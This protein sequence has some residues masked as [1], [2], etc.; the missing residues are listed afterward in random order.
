MNDKVIRVGI[1]G[2]ADIAAKR[3]L[4]AL[5]GNP[6]FRLAGIA[7]STADER[8]D[9]SYSGSDEEKS[10]KKAEELAGRFGGKVFRGY[11]SLLSSDEADAVYIPLPPAFHARWGSEAVNS[12]K[13]IFMEKPFTTGK[14]ETGKLIKLAE[15]KETAVFEN[16]GF[17]LHD[18]FSEIKRLLR[19]E[20]RSARTRWLR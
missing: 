20:C 7:A 8:G 18:Q 17:V 3:F 15:E 1:L 4:P 16:Y 6:R 2:A 10:L 14:E 5:A 19:E 13:H 9:R 12:G 11:R